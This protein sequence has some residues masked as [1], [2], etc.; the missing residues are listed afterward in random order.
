LNAEISSGN[1]YLRVATTEEINNYRMKVDPKGTMAREMTPGIEAKVRA[2]LE[3]TLRAE[4]EKKLNTVGIVLT[5]EQREVFQK[6]VVPPLDPLDDAKKLASTDV[7]SRLS[8][9]FTGGIKS[10][11][12]TILGGVAGT[13]KTTNFAPSIEDL[14]SDQ[15]TEK[16]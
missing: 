10:G 15:T 3:I 2:E 8:G 5:D 11:S 14:A 4:M 6:L 13:D 12:G 9:A 1:P 7:V 16:K